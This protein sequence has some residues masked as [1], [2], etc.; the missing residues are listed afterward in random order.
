MTVLF[1]YLV[2]SDLPSVHTLVQWRSLDKSLSRSQGT[3]K[4]RACLSGRPVSAMQSPKTLK[5]NH[6]C[7]SKWEKNE[8]PQKKRARRTYININ[9]ICYIS[10]QN[11]V[12]APSFTSSITR[13]SEITSTTIN[14]IS[15]NINNINNNNAAS[16]LFAVTSLPVALGTAV[17]SAVAAAV[18]NVADQ[19]TPTK[20][21]VGQPNGSGHREPVLSDGGSSYSNDI[22]YQC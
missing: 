6:T 9:D 15:N 21:P 8:L 1:W 5:I 13:V 4:T 3:R 19:C 12:P 11:C 14:S 18:P 2:K 22:I 10:A 16:N 7:S 17:E 20:T